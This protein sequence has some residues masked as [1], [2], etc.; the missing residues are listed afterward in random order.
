MLRTTKNMKDKYE[1][2]QNLLFDLIPEK[3]EEIY[4]Y[5]SVIEENNSQ[6]GEMYFYYLPKGLLKKKP[7]NVYEV[8]KRFNI[9]EKEYLKIVES[10]YQV[11]KDLKKDFIE[12]EQDVWT[13]ITISIA[14][15]K[16]KVEFKY[17]NIEQDE[18]ANYVRHVI[19]RYK[20]LHLGGELKEE[21]KILEE[22]L[23]HDI[24]AKV[25]TEEYQ[26][27]LY[28]KT[29][30]NAVG[31]DREVKAAQ[32]KQKE[33]ERKYEEQEQRKTKKRQEKEKKEEEKRLK[34][35]AKN[36]NQILKM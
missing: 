24:D 27:G 23:K 14:H 32:E 30:N 1:K 21:R 7:I 16:F 22:Y 33:Q 12:T 25:K 36:K 8:P 28:L 19:W 26:A 31:F 10:L 15:C 13:N 6:T 3:W 29:A 18:Y 9:N 11:I 34:E 2:I 5:A 20:Y 17:E 35:E 4:L